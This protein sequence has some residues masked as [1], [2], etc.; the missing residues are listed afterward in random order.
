M[1]ATPVTKQWVRDQSS[2]SILFHIPAWVCN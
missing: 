1:L 2:Y